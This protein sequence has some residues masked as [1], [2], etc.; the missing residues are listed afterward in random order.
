MANKKPRKAG[1][2]GRTKTASSRRA[3]GRT[4]GKKILSKKVSPRQ[5][6]GRRKKQALNCDALLF[7][8]RLSI[9]NLNLVEYAK[10]GAETLQ[11]KYP[12]LAFT[13]GRRDVQE[14]ADAMAPN[15]VKNRRW[16]MLTYASSAERDS[17]Q[18]WVDGHPEAVTAA[19]IS[20]GLKSIM[21]TWNDTQKAQLSRHFSGQAFDVHPVTVNAD[22]IKAFIRGLLHLHKFF[23]SEGGLTIWHADFDTPG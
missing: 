10:S 14:Q 2:P 19:D 3:I 8:P 23:E 9:D 6:K 7:L 21:D 4:S 11:A 1:L 22:K 5:A 20:A 15:V 12:D 17:L 16:I 13:S 18:Q